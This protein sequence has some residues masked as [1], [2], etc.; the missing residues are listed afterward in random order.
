MSVATTVAA[1][2]A[3]ALARQLYGLNAVARPLPGEYDAN[4]HLAADGAA[5]VLKV[6]HPAAERPVVELQAA[7]L[8]HLAAADPGVPLPRVQPTLA[9]E[10]IARAEVGG[11]ER[12]VWLLTYLP[13][14]LLA[15]ARPHSDTLLAGLG[16]YLG[17]LD[18]ALAGFAH[19]A[20]E[21]ELKWDLTRAGWAAE[22]LDAIADPARRALAARFLRRYEDEAAPL[23]PRLRRSVIHNDAN[24]YNVLVSPTDEWPQRVLG[25]IDF[26]DALLTATVCEVAIAAAY[27]LL[28]KA[29]P[30]AA[31][32]LVVGGYHSANPLSEDEVAALFPLIGARLAVSVVNSALRKAEQPD[33]PY[34]TVSEAPAWEALERLDSV[35]PRFAHYTLRHACGL[36]PQPQAG[37]VTAWLRANAASFAPVLDLD[38]RA[39]P[40]APLDL[41][42]G[43]L[44]LGAD[45]R[46]V[47]RDN[48]AATI[49]RVIREAGA[50]AAVGGYDEP[51][52]LY[53]APAFGADA[54]PTAER[55]TVHLGLDVWL[56]AGAPVYA[57]LAGTVRVLADNAARL[58]YGPLV[59]LEHTTGD[60]DTFFTLYGHLDRWCLENL[61]AGQAVA[62]GER[63]GTVGPP[64]L[65]G[66]WPPHLHMQIILDLLGLDRDYP[67]VALASQR[68]LW[69]AGSPDPN[70]ILGIPRERLPQPKPTLEQ[71][72]AERKARIGRNLSISYSRPLKIVRGW[73][74][75]LYDDTGRAYLDVYNN[76]PHVGHSHP[77]VVAAAQAQLALLNT[78][79]RY[80]HDN[81]VRYAERLTA[82]M[83]EP[84]SVCFFVNSASEA[85]EL[86]LRLARAHTGQR[87]M[88]V[89]D[90]AYHGHT[91]GLIDISPYK[92]NGPG[93]AGAPDWVH[94]AA[95]PDDYRGPF[96]RD[97]PEAGRKY[98]AEV[99]EL[100]D[101]LRGRGLA[102]YIAES[103]PSVGGQ[104]V[105][106]PGY[107]AAVYEAVR[108]AGGV[109]IADEVQVGFGRLGEAFWGFE[110]QG[111]APDIV[112][113]GK[114]IG[115]GFPLGAVVTTP[116]IADSFNNGMEYF[117]TF[118]GNPVACAAGL[119]VLDVIRD[120]GLQER[121]QRVGGR[122]LEGLRGLVERHPVVGDA[123]GSGLFLG[124]EL[125][126]DRVL[127][128]P[129]A[130][131]ASYVVN[132]LR[133]R[134]VLAGTDGP[135][136]N[137]IK[138]RP[139]MPFAEADADFLTGA[140]DAILAEDFVR[141]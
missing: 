36:P 33:D 8:A 126:R 101:G 102:G 15:D 127:L 21:R 83:P 124:L 3:Q 95:I 71:T 115:N 138:I 74:Q 38:L 113:L 135:Y 119:A 130:A 97:D 61:T 65:N 52:M 70:L 34:L 31:A 85:N 37:R 139:P 123:R 140:L 79:T 76:V 42:I 107:L 66:D 78:N 73:M 82:L 63:I 19:P 99:A 111:V 7:L 20:A 6:M 32:A 89:L 5:Y 81:I 4:F 105:L 96:K 29:D 24:D 45:P 22:R 43:S 92:F 64:P 98:A 39:A 14:R 59:I 104:I 16:A 122:L 109:C 121:A 132:R 86:A 84:L 112:V 129:A 91:T 46:A 68:A 23:L 25:V 49:E 106:P 41:S 90:A 100:I 9:G 47:E 12:L 17:R 50:Q 56:P 77:R 30:L 88:I 117:S 54:H 141:R 128:E 137:V 131:E 26:G 53:A 18:A 2:D 28:G 120:E 40:L 35:H 133:E 62:A 116:A 87:D 69:L 134:G 13:G 125:V 57:P 80:L 114:P 93:G 58:D 51:R 136:H 10:L 108:A 103:L 118:G 75:Y 1:S 94:V 60:G 48:L 55:R 27:A 11:Q 72:L 67:G 44:E 110:L